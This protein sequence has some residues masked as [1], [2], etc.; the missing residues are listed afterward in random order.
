MS[1]LFRYGVIGTGM[2]GMEHIQNIN[3]IEGAVVTSYSDPHP[4]SR[5][6]AEV[7]TED[8][9]AFADHRELLASGRCDAVVIAS[10]NQTHAEILEDAANNEECG[11]MASLFKVQEQ[12]LGMGGRAR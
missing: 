5:A 2:M 11:V 12:P 10:P 6:A 9:I 1:Q 3:H 7:I 4:D 8:A